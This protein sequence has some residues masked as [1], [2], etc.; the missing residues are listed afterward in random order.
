MCSW[1]QL[2]ILLRLLTCFFC[3]LLQLRRYPQLP[4]DAAGLSALCAAPGRAQDITGDGKF[5][6]RGDV[7]ILAFGKHAGTLL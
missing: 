3:L 4:R 5:Q 2:Y 6:W 1:L 7:P